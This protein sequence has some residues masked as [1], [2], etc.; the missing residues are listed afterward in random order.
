[1]H[2]TH[3]TEL[4]AAPIGPHIHT[5]PQ[6]EAVGRAEARIA[7]LQA[8][9]KVKAFEAQRLQVRAQAASWRWLAGRG[10]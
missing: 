3:C 9:L 5:P 6:R 7:E 4:H 10:G 8:E 1:M 2:F